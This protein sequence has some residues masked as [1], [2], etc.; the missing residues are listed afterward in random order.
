[1][2]EK[3]WCVSC[4]VDECVKYAEEYLEY[5]SMLKGSIHSVKKDAF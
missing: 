4:A 5:F 3:I 2:R 1:M